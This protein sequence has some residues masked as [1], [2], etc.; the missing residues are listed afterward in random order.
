MSSYPIKYIAQNGE[1]RDVYSRKQCSRTYHW[2]RKM[3]KAGITVTKVQIQ[4]QGQK[5]VLPELSLKAAN[6]RTYP[7]TIVAGKEK[8]VCHRSKDLHRVT[9]LLKHKK[10]QYVEERI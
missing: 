1:T 10:I 8:F 6:V 3:K 9:R 2:L 4:V 7:V 5:S